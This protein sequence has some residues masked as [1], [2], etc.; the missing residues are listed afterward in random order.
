MAS[1]SKELDKRPGKY[2][3]SSGMILC[4]RKLRASCVALDENIK[5]ISQQTEH[6]GVTLPLDTSK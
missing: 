2:D 5:V 4:F 3:V 1:L 6:S